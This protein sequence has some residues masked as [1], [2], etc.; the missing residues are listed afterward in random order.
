MS[1]VCAPEV[2]GAGERDDASGGSGQGLPAA[3][4]ER[5]RDRVPLQ[6]AMSTGNQGVV[7]MLLAERIG[8]VTKARSAVQQ[9]ETAAKGERAETR[10]AY[11]SGYYSCSLITRVGT[12]TAGTAESRRAIFHRLFQRYQRSEK[13]LVGALAEMY[14]QGMSTRKVKAVT[15]ALCGHSFS[16]S[17]ISNINKSLDE[18]LKAFAERRLDE[19]FPYLILDAR[20]EK[21][22]QARVIISSSASRWPTGRAARAGATSCSG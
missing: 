3:L 15:E 9:I 21:I 5:T 13:A 8:D 12:L 14:V 20:Y 7:L 19:P 16:A 1:P 11:R 2:G 18:A 10:L 6:W 4:Q 22:R 17:A